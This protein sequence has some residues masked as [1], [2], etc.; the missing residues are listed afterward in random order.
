MVKHDRKVKKQSILKKRSESEYSEEYCMKV[1][2]DVF[3]LTKEEING[4][5]WMDKKVDNN[6]QELSYE[7]G[8]EILQ[9][10]VYEM[11]DELCNS[12]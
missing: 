6:L 3:R 5:V 8:Q 4:G 12:Q 9:L 11:V 1:L 2:V 7:V 10:L